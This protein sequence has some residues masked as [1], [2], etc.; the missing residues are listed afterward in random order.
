MKK[1]AL[2]GAFDRNNYGD[3]LFPVIFEEIMKKMNVKVD[4]NYVGLKSK[5]LRSING[6]KTKNINEIYTKNN[7]DAIVVAGGDVLSVTWFNMFLC[8]CEFKI[9]YKFWSWLYYHISLNY[10]DDFFQKIMLGKTKLPWVIDKNKLNSNAKI[11]YNSVG[12]SH[13]SYLTKLRNEFKIDIIENMDNADYISVRDNKVC[14][15]LK[16]IGVIQ[17]INVSPDSAFVMSYLW[18]KDK[19]EKKISIETKNNEIAK[20]SYY[21]IQTNEEIGDEYVEILAEN[22]DKIYNKYKCP[23]VLLTIGRAAGHSDHIP[24]EKIAKKLKT[25]YFF[26]KNNTIFDTMYLL[27]NSNFY[28]GTSLHGA[29]TSF[30]YNKPFYSLTEKVP[31]LMAFMDTWGEKEDIKS[32]EPQNLYN[33]FP[34]LIKNNSELRKIKINKMQL[35]VLHNFESIVNVINNKL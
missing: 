2:V 22:I 18:S 32:I 30:S 17:N 14:N 6:Y 8:F 7:Y 5:D 12:G 23:V 1:I 26:P 15:D 25:P 35:E 3:I 34:N 19:L 31:K 27:S 16:E 21:I 13:I 4:I 33:S 28:I 24:L 9:I 29:I 10:R 20:N 11:I